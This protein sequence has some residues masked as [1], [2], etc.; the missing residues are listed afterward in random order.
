M[1]QHG[2]V[3]GITGVRE[4]IVDGFSLQENLAVLEE[5]RTLVQG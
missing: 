1:A 5:L 2:A 4:P 3:D